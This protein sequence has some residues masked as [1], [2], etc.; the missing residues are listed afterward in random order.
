MAMSGTRMMGL[1][2]S[3]P[4][5]RKLFPRIPTKLAGHPKRRDERR[6]SASDKA[7]IGA[8]PM[9]R[10]AAGGNACSAK[11]EA[12]QFAISAATGREV[13]SAGGSAVGE[14]VR[15]IGPPPPG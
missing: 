8:E 10:A 12:I 2:P 14:A 15:V 4:A 13:Q 9:N 6:W 3:K 7:K 1:C 5:V 11:P